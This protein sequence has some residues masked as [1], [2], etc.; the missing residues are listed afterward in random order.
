[1]VKGSHFFYQNG[2]KFVVRGIWYTD[3]TD[4]PLS[5]G[6]A[7][8]RDIQHLQNLGINTLV[9]PYMIHNTDHFDCMHI[10]EQ[11][12]IYVMVDLNGK[13]PQSFIRN[14][15][16][17]S[18]ANYDLFEHFENVVESYYKYPNTIGFFHSARISGAM[19][20]MPRYKSYVTH[21]K[22]FIKNKGSRTLPVGLLYTHTVSLGKVRS[23]LEV[24]LT[25]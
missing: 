12:R 24:D 8:A 9:V 2:T 22:T 17:Y 1:M 3:G 15:S 6:S 16:F 5:N 19:R 13:G 20:E 18:R 7:C 23:A 10:L 14:G 25:I 4:D 21:V 11:A